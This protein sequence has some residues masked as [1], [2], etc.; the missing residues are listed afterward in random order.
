MDNYRHHKLKIII[1][2]YFI[3]YFLI[4]L[5]N[6]LIHNLFYFHHCCILF[7]IFF[8][9]SR[10]GSSL[11]NCR[12]RAFGLILWA[13]GGLGSGGRG[14]IFLECCWFLRL[15]GFM[16]LF[17]CQFGSSCSLFCNRSQALTSYS[18]NSTHTHYQSRSRTQTQTDYIAPPQAIPD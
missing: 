17:L 12:M 2:P 18:K 3:F 11:G 15:L 10:L 14:L 6:D 5:F 9:R 7:W 13:G 4:R 1:I 8:G 16:G